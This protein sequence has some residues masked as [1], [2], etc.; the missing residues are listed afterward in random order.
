MPRVEVVGRW[1][2]NH[3]GMGKDLWP[4]T[5]SDDNG[6]EAPKLDP[7]NVNLGGAIQVGLNRA[8]KPC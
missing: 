7:V 5:V 6:L 1:G 8:L 3:V 2:V 4:M